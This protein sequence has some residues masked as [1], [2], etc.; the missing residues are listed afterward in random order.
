M[1]FRSRETTVVSANAADQQEVIAAYAM[2]L[3]NVD[4]TFTRSQIEHALA[5][6]GTLSDPLTVGVSVDA[7]IHRVAE[8]PGAFVL[9]SLYPDVASRSREDPGATGQGVTLPASSVPISARA[10]GNAVV[11]VGAGDVMLRYRMLV[12]L[13]DLLSLPR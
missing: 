9:V 5:R 12:A 6:A 1:L 8:E 4:R 3:R 11:L 2:P 10:I 13:D 7:L